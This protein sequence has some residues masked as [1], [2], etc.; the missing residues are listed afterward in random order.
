MT[1]EGP[2]TTTT[3]VPCTYIPTYLPT[4]YGSSCMVHMRTIRTTT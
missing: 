1:K 4:I 2:L 3:I